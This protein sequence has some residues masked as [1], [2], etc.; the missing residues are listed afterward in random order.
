MCWFWNTGTCLPLQFC[1]TRERKDNED[2]LHRVYA[3]LGHIK[4]LD[5]FSVSDAADREGGLKHSINPHTPFNVQVPNV[6]IHSRTA[7]LLHKQITESLITWKI[8][9]R[10][11]RQTQRG[12]SV[13]RCN[14]PRFVSHVHARL[15]LLA[16]WTE[17]LVP[18]NQRDAWEQWLVW[19]LKNKIFSVKLLPC[20]HS[21]FVS[22]RGTDSVW[23]LSELLC[24][25]YCSAF[26][27]FL[28]WSLECGHSCVQ[29]L[30]FLHSCESENQINMQHF[31]LKYS[32]KKKSFSASE[33]GCP[34]L[35]P[36]QINIRVSNTPKWQGGV[37]LYSSQ[38]T[39]FK[40]CRYSIETI[41]FMILNYWYEMEESLTGRMQLLKV[42]WSD[43]LA[44]EFLGK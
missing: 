12:S 10:A 11:F 22:L 41:K 26:W 18:T 16:A 33:S 9:S 24:R 1:T 15:Q 8:A 28:L 23:I 6:D 17:T 30:H 32:D 20:S 38:A 43:Q 36:L 39:K 44:R 35:S 27:E 42:T 25:L 2:T 19:L 13:R 31:L 4:T 21:P 3:L 37:T 7:R 14:W 29:N 34:N 5:C 40:Y